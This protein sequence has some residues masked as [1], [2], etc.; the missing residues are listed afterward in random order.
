MPRTARLTQEGSWYH[1]HAKVAGKAGEYVLADAACQRKMFD[2]LRHYSHAY[3]AEVSSFCIMGNH[4]HG[5]IC[6]EAPRKIADEELRMRAKR[7]Y[8]HSRALLEQW[9]ARKW[10]LFGERLFRLS[11]FMRNV[12]AAFARW[13]NKTYERQGRFWSDRFKSTLLAD[14]E[15][16]LDCMLYID[17]NPVRA[18]IVDRPEEYHGGSAYLREL[19]LSDWLSPLHPLLGRRSEEAGWMDYKARLYYRGSVPT[20]EGQAAIPE[21]VLRAEMA[22]GFKRSGIFRKRLRHFTDGVM[23]GGEVA[24]RQQLVAMIRDG[25]YLRRK[26]PIPQLDGLQY[27]LREQRGHAVH[28]G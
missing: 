9:T 26:N 14:V 13:Y 10:E 20:K 18:G 3:C 12:Q 7:M 16:R 11:E 25:R 6:F 2:I 21:A 19:G 1:V 4:W 28:L 27:S 15:A 24:I 8:P 22:R 17:L 5:V 23:I